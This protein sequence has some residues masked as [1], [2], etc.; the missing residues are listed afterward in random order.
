M[1]SVLVITFV[2]VFA[3]AMIGLAA[4]IRF[5]YMMKTCHK[6]QWLKIGSP[7]LLGNQG[8][9]EASMITYL[10]LREYVSLDDPKTVRSARDLRAVGVALLVCICVASATIFGIVLFGKHT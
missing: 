1:G 4:R 9:F 3:I 2:S 6:E 7:S 5:L 8:I 10:R